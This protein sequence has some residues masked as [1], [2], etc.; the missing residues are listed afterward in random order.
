MP[1]SPYNITITTTLGG[2]SLP[3]RSQQFFGYEK[4]AGYSIAPI[5]NAFYDLSV[6]AMGAKDYADKAFS[7]PLTRTLFV[8]PVSIFAFIQSIGLNFNSTIDGIVET[9]DTLTAGK[10]PSTWVHLSANKERLAI[11]IGFTLAMLVS[12]G[13][14]CGGYWF[15]DEAPEDYNIQDDVNL[16]YWKFL[17]IL[18]GVVAMVTTAFTEGF[19]TYQNVR[20]LIAGDKTPYAT[21]VPTMLIGYPIVFFAAL[22]AASETYAGVKNTVPYSTTMFLKWI[23]LAPSAAKILTDFFF[24]GRLTL[25]ALDDFINEMKDTL[26]KN[27]EEYSGI[28]DL[29]R[30]MW[31]ARAEVAAFLGTTGAAVWVEYSQI[32]LTDDLLVDEATKLPFDVHYVLRETLGW[33]VTLRDGIL[34][35]ATLYPVF[36]YLAHKSMTVKPRPQGLHFQSEETVP[37]GLHVDLIDDHR[38]ELSPL[39]SPRGRRNSHHYKSFMKSHLTFWRLQKAH[40]ERELDTSVSELMQAT[41]PR[42][43]SYLSNGHTL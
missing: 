19:E 5:G 12:F 42:Y 26:H 21:H 36:L 22:E 15:V 40:E 23:L 33:S 37:L 4:R 27:Y 30:V 13:D 24:P 10:I 38:H 41:H 7:G 9:V 35:M 20:T 31:E 39:I 11:T 32:A 34:Q 28:K 8:V 16:S 17:S 1:P 14:Y 3:P 29:L 18:T 25:S 43:N 6:M 2:V